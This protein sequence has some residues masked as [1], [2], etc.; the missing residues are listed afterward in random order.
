MSPSGSDRKEQDLRRA[1]GSSIAG[2]EQARLDICVSFF[3]LERLVT[4]V[5]SVR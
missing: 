1:T 4:N 3:G 2:L 5:L